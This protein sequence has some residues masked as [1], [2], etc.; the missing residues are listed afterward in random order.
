V[1]GAGRIQARLHEPIAKASDGELLAQLEAAVRSLDPAGVRA[2]GIG[3]PG[4]V[5]HGAGRVRVA[6]AVPVLDGLPLG[7]LLG[8]RLSRPVV[9]ENDANAAAL[10]EAW[11][12]AGRGARSLPLVTLGTGIGGGVSAAG[13]FLADRIVAE[14][15]ARV[16]P[17]V[18]ADCSFRVAELGND[19]GARGAARGGMLATA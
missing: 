2:V 1:D 14:T 13:P 11:A 9:L 8:A 16:F 4:I 15:R 17:Q 19:A 6:P 18:F 10:G 12:G 5:E 3:L 7:R